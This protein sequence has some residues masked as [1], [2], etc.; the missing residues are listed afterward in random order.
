MRSTP[1]LLALALS[2]APAA[3]LTAN[4]IAIPPKGEL[5]DEHASILI[6]EAV[7]AQTYGNRVVFSER[8]FKATLLGDV[9]TVRGTPH[10]TDCVG[11]VAIVDISKNGGR[12]LRIVHGK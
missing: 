12:V 9:W 3:G 6:A 2:M 5:V 8:P 7:V 1:L 10:C 4:T 11:G